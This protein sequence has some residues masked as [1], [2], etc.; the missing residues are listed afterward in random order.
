M[1]SS[2]QAL[3]RGVDLLTLR[4]FVALAREGRF[5]RAA[6]ALGVQQPTLS[7]QVQR[8]EQEFRAKL[9]VRRPRGITLTAAGERLLL[10]AEAA[11]SSLEV[12]RVEIA[13]LS[14]RLQGPV[15]LGALSTVGAYFLPPVIASF[16]QH[17]PAVQISVRE[18][19]PDGLEAL[20]ARGDL[21]LA[22][23]AAPVRRE[24]LTAGTLWRE[25]YVLVVPPGHRL[26]GA[27]RTVTLAEVTTE[28]FIL[29]PA[30][31]SLEVVEAACAKQ[32]R[33]P[34][35]VVHT[36]SLETFKRMV[37]AGVGITLLPRIIT[38]NPGE[39]PGTV[40]TLS[41][42]EASRKVVLLYRNTSHLTPAA[43][44]LRDAIVHRAGRGLGARI[45][46]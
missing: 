6:R 39:W 28:P 31:R 30:S 7:R 37:A 4:A 27:E 41:P 46:A 38:L 35:V 2:P 14:G 11:L 3:D 18:G 17:H 13:D 25:D 40:V 23:S 9:V 20:V 42:G 45:P 10:Y 5:R 21:D 24:G 44:A 12:A 16:R 19:L 22:I 26:A 1:R 29:A 32:G 33:R 36:D 15:A 8:L 34:I 43:R